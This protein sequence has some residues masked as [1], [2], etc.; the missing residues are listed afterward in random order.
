[1]IPENINYADA[2]AAF[3]LARAAR[4]ANA[5]EVVLPH[6]LAAAKANPQHP[7]LWQMLGLFYRT[8]DQLAPAV[9]AFQHAADLAP[10]DA[11]IAHGHAR[12]A[13]EAGL[14]ATNLYN[15]AQRLA[16]AEASILIGRSA[17]QLAEKDVATA[18]S[19]LE[20]ILQN[21]PAWQEG[22]SALS[23]LLWMSGDHARLTQS[24]DLALAR[25]PNSPLLWSQLIL[26]LVQTRQFG[27]VLEA[28]ARGRRE[29]G[30]DDA[31]LFLEACSC[32]EL[33]MT[34][35]ADAL[36]ATIGETDNPMLVEHRIRHLLRAGR[37][38]EARDFAEG[39]LNGSTHN[40][41][42]PY[43]YIA[44]RL[45]ND[46]RW[47]RIENDPDLLG[48]YDIAD[49]LP[50]LDELAETLRSL[51]FT[52][53]EPM[54]QSLRGGTQTDGP[55]LSRID[56]VIQHLRKALMAT[57]EQHATRLIGSKSATGGAGGARPTHRFA[58]SWSVLL[59]GAGHHANHVHQAG[60]LS[61][62]LYVA[63]PPQEE[64]GPAPAGWF[65]IGQPPVELGID[66]PP[67]R[68][69]EPKAG[70]LVLFSSTMWHGTHPIKGGER[71]TV[72]FDVAPPA[73]I[74]LSY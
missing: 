2:Q 49:E 58:G 63:L 24:V 72:A 31:F 56:P 25:T 37:T 53:H 32:A 23:R 8:L 27:K 48:I 28:I 22:H 16:P 13:L 46:D 60:W 62:A 20:V 47:T 30:Q 14:P 68:T 38:A 3:E 7:G 15:I 54:E 40:L 51:H 50:P 71:L 42:L 57:V 43:A 18:I 19:D 67:I 26:T 12:V 39:F 73:G 36:F 10:N 41:I 21:N 45:L 1:M 74:G 52:Q 55:L 6:L 65:T 9:A 59:K 64:M 17:A 33:G 66:L 34:E 29:L 70:R 11:S 69:V 5:E 4:S 61:S 35:K 44:W